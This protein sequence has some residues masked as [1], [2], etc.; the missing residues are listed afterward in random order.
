MPLEAQLLDGSTG[1]KT[2]GSID[3][4]RATAPTGKSAHHSSH[5]RLQMA[6]IMAGMAAKRV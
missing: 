1:A 4:Q 2:N 5:T 6:A 3:S